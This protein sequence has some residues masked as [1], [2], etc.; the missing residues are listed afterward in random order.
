MNIPQPDTLFV[1]SITDIKT[2]THTVILLPTSRTVC[3]GLCVSGDIV[4]DTEPDYAS[5]SSRQPLL[6]VHNQV[7]VC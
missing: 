7:R 2:T 3:Q 1:L 5:V 6:S 4:T